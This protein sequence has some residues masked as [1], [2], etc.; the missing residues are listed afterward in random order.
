MAGILQVEVEVYKWVGKCLK[1]VYKSVWKAKPPH[2]YL[3]KVAP[4]LPQGNKKRIDPSQPILCLPPMLPS[5]RFVLPQGK[6]TFEHLLGRLK[7][8]SVVQKAKPSSNHKATGKGRRQDSFFPQNK[9]K[10]T[11]SWYSGYK[12][13]FCGHEKSQ[14]NRSSP[15]GLVHGFCQK[16]AIFHR[17]CFSAK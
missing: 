7:C 15:K 17:L 13:M 9:T 10:K 1:L 6:W 4:P 11:V 8:F 2:T 12:R 16:M 14:K 5:F 3:R